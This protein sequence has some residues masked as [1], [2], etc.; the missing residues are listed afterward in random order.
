MKRL[1]A[2]KLK[3][4]SIAVG[5]ALAGMAA[6]PV[7]AQADGVNKNCPE[8]SVFY[9]PGNGE[10]IVVPKGFKVEVFAKGLNFPTDIAFVGNKHDF[11]VYIL[12]S[13]TGLPGKCNTNAGVYGG[14]FAP[15]NPFTPSLSIYDDN[16]N[17]ISGRLGK[18]T[19]SGGGF[20]PD[21]P[22]I[23]LSFEHD[24]SGG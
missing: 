22:A 11:K 17:R 8:E 10:D 5:L 20:Q 18:P 6:V 1:I 14:P 21:G 7:A 13:G 2:P 15:D 9:N 16:G 4:S 3:L 24:T 23:G 19:P 12:E